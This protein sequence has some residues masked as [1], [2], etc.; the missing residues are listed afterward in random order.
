MRRIVVLFETVHITSGY[1]HE[2]FEALKVSKGER[3][4]SS[5]S[6]AF[7]SGQLTG[8]WSENPIISILSY[9]QLYA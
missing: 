8:K 3:A 5:V 2:C 4:I 6:F 1:L 9:L 7:T